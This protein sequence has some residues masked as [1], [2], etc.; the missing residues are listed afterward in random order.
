MCLKYCDIVSWGLSLLLVRFQRFLIHS[1]GFLRGFQGVQTKM[2]TTGSLIW[3]LFHCVAFPQRDN[4]RIITLIIGFVVSMFFSPH[5]AMNPKWYLT[6]VN[7]VTWH[8]L[9]Y[10]I[11][12]LALTESVVQTVS[13]MPGSSGSERISRR[14]HHSSIYSQD[15]PWHK[16][17]TLLP[18]LD[19][20]SY[21]TRIKQKIFSTG[22]IQ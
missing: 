9:L 20:N 2:R 10:Q 13:S 7:S 8:C 18:L 5:T 1:R 15:A 17:W 12:S 21:A 16:Y 3:Q 19:L 11:G 4:V 22:S 14:S 6:N